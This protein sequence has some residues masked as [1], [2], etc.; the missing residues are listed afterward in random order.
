MN[1]NFF[2]YPLE[3][4]RI[5]QLL[6]DGVQVCLRICKNLLLA[7][8]IGH[9]AYQPGLLTQLLLAQVIA[10]EISLVFTWSRGAAQAVAVMLGIHHIAETAAI[11]RNGAAVSGTVGTHGCK[12]LQEPVLTQRVHDHL[13]FILEFVGIEPVSVMRPPCVPELFSAMSKI[14]SE[15]TDCCQLRVLIR[16][17]LRIKKTRL[18]FG[19]RL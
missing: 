18:Y 10:I 2:L 16:F 15:M 12:I 5:G 14:H 4:F 9:A 3:L 7:A 19:G 13:K 1:S 6:P 11:F 17:E 8:G